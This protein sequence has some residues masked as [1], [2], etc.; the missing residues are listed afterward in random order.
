MKSLRCILTG[1][2]VHLRHHDL[3]E[4]AGRVTKVSNKPRHSV[5]RYDVCASHQVEAVIPHDHRVTGSRGVHLREK[6]APTL[7]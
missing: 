1:C 7:R 4:P 6:K 5:R 3:C 2:P